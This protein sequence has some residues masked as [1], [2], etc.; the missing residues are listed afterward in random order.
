MPNGT[1]AG[2]CEEA[3]ASSSTS[4]IRHDSDGDRIGDPILFKVGL[5]HCVVR[6]PKSSHRYG[7]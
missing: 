1:R 2:S 6:V 7:N 4:G 3:D 5:E